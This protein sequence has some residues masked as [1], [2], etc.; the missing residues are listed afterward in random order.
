MTVWA[1]NCFQ[2][3]SIHRQDQWRNVFVF[4]SFEKALEFQLSDFAKRYD[5][6][7]I[8]ECDMDYMGNLKDT[9]YAI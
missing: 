3:E 2:D 9:D 4:S 7:D 8:T 5:N 1:V 6:M